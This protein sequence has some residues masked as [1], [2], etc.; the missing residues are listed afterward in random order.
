MNSIALKIAVNF[1]SLEFIFVE[2]GRMY[3]FEVAAYN[4]ID[5]GLPAHLNVTTPENGE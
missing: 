3:Q 1:A 2:F 4:N 5:I